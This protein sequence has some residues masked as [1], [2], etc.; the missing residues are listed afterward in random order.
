MKLN[1]NKVKEIMVEKGVKSQYR[2][3]QLAETGTQNIY[4]WFQTESKNGIEP[5]AK[6][7]GINPIDITIFDS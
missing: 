1:I 4:Y 6:A 3:A 2:L 7:L 5:I